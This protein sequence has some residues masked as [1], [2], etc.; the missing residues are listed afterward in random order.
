MNFISIDFYSHEIVLVLLSFV[1][2]LSSFFFSS[3]SLKFDDAILSV[4]VMFLKYFSFIWQGT[5]LDVENQDSKYDCKKCEHG[6]FCDRLGLPRPMGECAPGHYCDRRGATSAY[7]VKDVP[8][9]P[10]LRFG[11]HAYE[12]VCLFVRV[13][14]FAWACMHACIFIPEC[15][16][17]GACVFVCACVVV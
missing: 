1:S 3:P 14:V 15:A 16:R 2:G 8:T 5:Y 13:Y 9:F 12:R 4:R 7:P 11:E 17:V 6:H 10:R